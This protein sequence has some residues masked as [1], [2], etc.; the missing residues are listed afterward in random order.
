M[1]QSSCCTRRPLSAPK[2]RVNGGEGKAGC[3]N[4]RMQYNN[5]LCSTRRKES[6]I[7]VKKSEI[8]NQTNDEIDPSSP[9]QTL[10][11]H[12]HSTGWLCITIVH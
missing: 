3:A 6:K 4:V 12:N 7:N 11:S 9:Q 10:G 5:S 2:A 1:S 8:Y